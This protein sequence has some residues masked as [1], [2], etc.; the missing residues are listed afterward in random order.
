MDTVDDGVSTGRDGVA[1]AAAAAAVAAVTTTGGAAGTEGLRLSSG[2]PKAGTWGAEGG[3]TALDR[4]GSWT[5][6]SD[7]AEK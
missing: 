7:L 4:L 2:S 6:F 5:C 3:E 1:A